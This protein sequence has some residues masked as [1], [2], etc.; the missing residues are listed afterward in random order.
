[1]LL[2]LAALVT[3][4]LATGVT[5]PQIAA[6]VRQG[7]QALSAA[8]AGVERAIA[9]FLVS[10]NQGIVN[11][12]MATA[13]DGCPTPTPAGTTTLYSA[14]ALGN[15]G[16]YTVTYRPISFA[17]L[18]LEST[19]TT[20][21]GSIPRTVR[22]VVTKAYVAR[23]GVLGDDVE[24]TGN[25]QVLG[26]SGAVHGNTQTKL[27]GSSFVQQTA[28]TASTKADD[29]K[30]CTVPCTKCTPPGPS[31]QGVG[32]PSMSGAGKP[33]E[34]I[35][36]VAPSSFISSATVVLGDGTT[37]VTC[38]GLSVTVP[39]NQ[40]LNVVAIGAV[41]ACTLTPED[42]GIFQGW[43]MNGAGEWEFSGSSTPPNGTYYASK[44]IKITSSPGSAATP[45]QATLIAGGTSEQGEVKIDG[46][47]NMTPFFNDLLTLAGEVELKGNATLKGTVMASGTGKDSNS[48]IEIEGNVNLTGNLI[49]PGEIE[50][51]G[52]AK[53][54]Y[55]VG[56]RTRILS[57]T[58]RILSWSTVSH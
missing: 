11:C 31:S 34:P 44:E 13:A 33:A 53:I 25:G 32:V 9:Y 52:S 39:K 16:T 18:L 36:T 38:A 15:V 4:L 37:S 7:G 42:T 17:T 50:V 56:T 5:E 43:K 23:F 2:A 47:P 54:T 45:W 1:M 49:A 12:A 19:G 40:I 58:L 6:N 24:I 22:V 21:I 57:P 35:P 51:T 10:A 28:T 26:N 30:N 55:N 41:T 8:E 20:T 3:A 46:A 48:S 27:G 14:Q 29:C